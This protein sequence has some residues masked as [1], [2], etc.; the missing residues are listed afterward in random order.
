[1]ALERGDRIRRPVRTFDAKRTQT[2]FITHG[3][4]RRSDGVGGRARHD[5]GRWRR[6]RLAFEQVDWIHPRF[7]ADRLVPG[8][9]SR[10][11]QDL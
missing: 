10:S 1:M 5:N 3:W 6:A 11:E 4:L 7:R 9:G 2:S 8:W